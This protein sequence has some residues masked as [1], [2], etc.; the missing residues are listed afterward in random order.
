M[1]FQEII[2][3][4]LLKINNFSITISKIIAFLIIITIIN[5]IRVILKRII[6]KSERSNVEEYKKYSIY[7]L[8][9][10]FLWTIGIVIGLEAIGVSITI[11]LAGSAALLVGIGLGLQQTFND[12]VSGLILLFEGSIKL[13]DVVVVDNEFGKIVEIGLRTSKIETRNNI[14]MIIP[15]SKFIIENVINW[16]YNNRQ[17]RFNVAV[18]V[19]Y[20]SDLEIVKKTLIEVAKDNSRVLKSP[21]PSVEFF[22]FGD[23]GLELN[24]FYWTEKGY[25]SRLISS[26]LR[27]EID[28][29]FRLN[30]VVIPFPQRDLNIKSGYKD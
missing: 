6:M 30:N 24:L 18:S 8:S 21:E 1:D 28:K 15:N 20:G 7:R 27:F 3:F 19:A 13:N 29:R 12:L 10:Y 4:E 25:E 23:S 26:Q 22:N 16:S 9:S 17:T 2:N 11:L 5:F 14:I